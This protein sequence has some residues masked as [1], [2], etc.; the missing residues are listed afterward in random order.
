MAAN[1][2]KNILIHTF[3]LQCASSNNKDDLKNKQILS[4]Q[5]L[6]LF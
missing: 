2:F 6:G 5:I 3:S 4:I 1:K